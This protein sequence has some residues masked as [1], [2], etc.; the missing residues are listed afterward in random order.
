MGALGQ[1]GYAGVSMCPCGV[2]SLSKRCKGPP[3]VRIVAAS[4]SACI[5]KNDK[6]RKILLAVTGLSPQI[7]T[8]TLYA[9]AVGQDTPWVPDEIHLITS[10]EGADR[11]RLSL[12]DPG[13]GQ[14]YALCRDYYERE[15]GIELPNYPRRVA[16]CDRVGGDVAGHHGASAYDAARS[17]R[18]AGTDDGAAADPDIVTYGD[19]LAIDVPTATQSSV[20]IMGGGIELDVGGYHHVVTDDDGADIQQGDVEVEVTV[21]A[22]ADVT[23]EFAAKRGRNDTAGAKLLEQFAANLAVAAVAGLVLVQFAQQGLPPIPQRYD[24]RIPAIEGLTA[25]HLLPFTHDLGSPSNCSNGTAITKVG[26]RFHES[27]PT[28]TESIRP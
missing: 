21:S 14:F 24:L 11:A 26:R 8:E 9:L 5:M 16:E 10:C 7:V 23:A 20:F 4:H 18:D 6:K 19:G 22:D 3:E 27:L 12:L 1:A 17:D 28:V 13:A 15:H 25:A 2:A